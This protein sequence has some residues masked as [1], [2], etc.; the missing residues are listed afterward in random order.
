[1]NGKLAKYEGVSSQSVAEVV[2]GSD[3]AGVTAA[4]GRDIYAGDVKGFGVVVNLDGKFFEVLVSYQ[5]G[6]GG[7]LLVDDGLVDEES[8]TSPLNVNSKCQCGGVQQGP[9]QRELF[10]C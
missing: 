5:G 4:G 7:N 2:D 8:K 6:R 1:M 9:I 3:V 10:F